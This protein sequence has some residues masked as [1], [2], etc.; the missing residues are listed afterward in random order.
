[1]NPTLKFDDLVSKDEIQLT[2]V[3][4]PP[5]RDGRKFFH[6]H[7]FSEIVSRQLP[8]LRKKVHFHRRGLF[9]PLTHF[10]KIRIAFLSGQYRSRP[11]SSSVRAS[12]LSP[13]QNEKQKKNKIPDKS[14]F[15]KIVSRKTRRFHDLRGKR[16]AAGKRVF[17]F[18]DI[19]GEHLPPF[20]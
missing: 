9:S 6:E 15:F 8:R 3:Y 14:I 13:K 10:W 17:L 4:R 11:A 12:A 7:Y 19:F 18:A 1:M 20:F 2:V 16:Y 5:G